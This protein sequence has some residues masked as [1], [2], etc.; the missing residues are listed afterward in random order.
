[1]EPLQ[2]I[3][4]SAFLVDRDPEKDRPD[5]AEYERPQV[6]LEHSVGEGPAAAAAAILVAYGVR[7]GAGRD[8]RAPAGQQNV[9]D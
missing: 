4:V 7:A 5:P 9:E 6:E 8:H 2:A 3:E 1:M